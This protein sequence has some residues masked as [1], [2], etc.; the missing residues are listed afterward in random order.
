LVITY[1][2]T[3]AFDRLVKQAIGKRNR[4]SAY[5]IGRV[6]STVIWI[7]GILA[8]L[9]ILGASE[10]VI[11]V[12]ILLVGAYLI[13]ATREFSNNWFAGQM[14]KAIAPFKIGDWIRTTDGSYGRVTR[15]ETLYTLLV[16]PQN[17]IVVIPNSKLT[18]DLLLNRTTSGSLKV[19][20]DL[21]L[22]RKVEFGQFTQAVSRILEDMTPYL[23][24]LGL[25][26]SE[27][28]V[29]LVSTLPDHVKVRVFLR[30]DNPAKEEEVASEFRKRFNLLGLERQEASVAD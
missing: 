21:E 28:E 9:P 4:S 20:V 23:S 26:S 27:P 11:A 1:G 30:I 15:I 6:G 14:I 8:I 10:I 25:K 7:I 29:Y 22:S 16:T 13:L 3:F 17:E 18:S 24:D 19:P 5:E 12:V 2:I